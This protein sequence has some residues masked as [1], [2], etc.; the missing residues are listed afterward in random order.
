MQEIY[1]VLQN[2]DTPGNPLATMMLRNVRVF[3]K[4]A[5][6]YRNELRQIIKEWK[7]EAQA[8]SLQLKMA[9]QLIQDYENCK[10]QNRVLL[11]G[12]DQP[13]F[14]F[15]NLAPEK[16]ERFDKS[17]TKVELVKQDPKMTKVV[18]PRGTSLQR[19]TVHAPYSGQSDKRAHMG[20]KSTVRSNHSQDSH[21]SSQTTALTTFSSVVTMNLK[22]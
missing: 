6:R 8:Q 16:Y 2:R 4:M 21:K 17:G 10:S 1:K 14:F 20:L 18:P 3:A 11:L 7:A 15:Q 5:I 9:K 19:E 22:K 12:F 13:Q